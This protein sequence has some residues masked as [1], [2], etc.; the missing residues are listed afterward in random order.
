MSERAGECVCKTRNFDTKSI[1]TK[2][3]FLRP[4][5]QTAT[6]KTFKLKYDSNSFEKGYVGFWVEPPKTRKREIRLRMFDKQP[7]RWVA[8]K[9]K[10]DGV[11]VVT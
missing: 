9:G 7:A 4:P 2:H 5:N 1:G 3:K 8:S 10:E 6:M 11:R